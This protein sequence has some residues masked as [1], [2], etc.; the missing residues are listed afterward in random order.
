MLT[1]KMEVSP[2]FRPVYV[3]RRLPVETIPKAMNIPIFEILLELSLSFWRCGGGKFKPSPFGSIFQSRM[4]II[5][6][7]A[8]S[9][10]LISMTHMTKWNPSYVFM[11]TFWGSVLY[12]RRNNS[13]IIA[14][15]KPFNEEMLSANR[16]LTGM[17]GLSFPS[18]WT[19]SAFYNIRR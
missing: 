12:F 2:I 1:V 5:K 8:W 3:R 10:D 17:L 18:N 11:T 16:Q 19:F 6:S 13:L 9:L 7:R 4:D 14:A 15:S